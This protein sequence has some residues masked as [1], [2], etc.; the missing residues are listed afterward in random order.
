VEK[1][2]RKNNIFVSK[3]KKQPNGLDLTISDQKK[4]QKLGN[5][6]KENFGGILKISPRLHTKDKQT[7]KEIYRVN[8][9]YEMPDYKV[10]DILKID[11]KLIL[12]SGIR[13]NIIGKNLVSMKKISIEMKNK[14]YSILKSRETTVSKVYPRLEVLDPET[15]QSVKIENS[16]KVK[17]GEKVKVVNDSGRFYIL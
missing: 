12:I 10:G 9:F 2:V 16:K 13:K 1:F 8:V 7:S 15:F 3:T 14:E 11:N 4:I 5:E 6:L 17:L